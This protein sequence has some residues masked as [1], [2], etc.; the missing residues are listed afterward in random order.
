MVIL[1]I[2]VVG[3]LLIIVIIFRKT[4]I[5]LKTQIL[6]SQ[7]CLQLQRASGQML[8]AFEVANE[9]LGFSFAQSGLLLRNLN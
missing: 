2:I 7:E 1:P 4:A 3:V 9:L 6:K 5:I 8:T